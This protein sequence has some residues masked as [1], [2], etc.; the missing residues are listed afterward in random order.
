MTELNI[1]AGAGS[2]AADA[3]SISYL[4][5]RRLCVPDW[6]SQLDFLFECQSR[7][8]SLPNTHLRPWTDTD[9]VLENKQDCS[10]LVA[11]SGNL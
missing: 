1:R 10:L 3:I 8:S 5:T 9:Y 7:C 2:V 4:I 6:H 11:C